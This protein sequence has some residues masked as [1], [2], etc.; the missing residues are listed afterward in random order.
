MSTSSYKFDIEKLATIFITLV[1]FVTVS[2]TKY[3]YGYELDDY[4][5]YQDLIEYTNENRQNVYLYTVPSLQFRYYAY[6]VYEMPPKG[7]FSN[8][9]VLGGWDMYTQNYYD[10]KNR[11][12]LEGK[13]TD[14]LKDNVYLIDGDVYWSGRRYENYKENIALFIKENYNKDVDFIEIKKF[15]NLTIYKV[16]ERQLNEE[17]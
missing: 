11:Y 6:S 13:M 14:L 3:Q 16:V 7:A 9:R 17:Q 8:L 12:N 15:D 2:G 4:L 5:N 10:F 1:I